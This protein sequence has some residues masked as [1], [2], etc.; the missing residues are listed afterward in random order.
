[1][2]SED[3]TVK[4]IDSKGNTYFR[5]YNSPLVDLYKSHSCAPLMVQFPEL[6]SCYSD[7]GG[8]MSLKSLCGN[9]MDATEKMFGILMLR[10][11][12]QVICFWAVVSTRCGVH[13]LFPIIFL[14]FQTSHECSTNALSFIV[15]ESETWFVY[16]PCFWIS[17]KCNGF[18][19]GICYSLQFIKIIRLVVFMYSCW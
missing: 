15:N 14:I 18:G 6:R 16:L 11:F 19:L 2:S 3:I 4:S 1:M 17:S 9:I 7:F 5:V 10:V 12:K 13:V 8:F